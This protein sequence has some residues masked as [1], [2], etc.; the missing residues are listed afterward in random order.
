MSYYIESG[1]HIRDKVK[2]VLDLTN[3]ATEKN[4]NLQQV[5]IHL[6]QLLKRLCRLKAAVDKLDIN[7]LANVPTSLNSSKTKLDDLDV[8]KLKPVPVDLQSSRCSR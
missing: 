2:V 6:N 8:Y 5:L 4:Q 7:K 1:N 3:Y